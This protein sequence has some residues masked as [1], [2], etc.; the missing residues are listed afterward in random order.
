MRSVFLQRGNVRLAESGYLHVEF[1]LNDCPRPVDGVVG[2][3]F[4]DERHLPRLMQNDDMHSEVFLGAEN[5]VYEIDRPMHDFKHYSDDYSHNRFNKADDGLYRFLNC[6]L[7]A[8]P[9][10]HGSFPVWNMKFSEESAAA[11]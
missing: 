11:W 7:Y 1:V 5:I 3:L 4:R 2:F 9:P 6:V 8:G 10:T